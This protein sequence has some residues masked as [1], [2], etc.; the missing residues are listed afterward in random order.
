[1]LYYLLCSFSFRTEQCIQNQPTITIR[2]N[3]QPSSDMADVL[4]SLKRAVVHPGQATSEKYENHQQHNYHHA[5]VLLSPNGYSGSICEQSFPQQA[6]MFPSMSVNV[7]MN[8]TMHGY[9]PSG[10]YPTTEIQYPQVLLV[11]FKCQ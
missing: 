7:S 9:H 8:M 4:L 11:Y 5:P 2:E 6:P 1:M 3:K 10:G